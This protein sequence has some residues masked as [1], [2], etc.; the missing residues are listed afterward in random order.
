MVQH[1]KLGL[2][3]DLNEKIY[4]DLQKVTLQDIV[5]FE[6]QHIA[7]KPYRYVILGDEQE[8]DMAALNAIG[9]VRRISTEEIFGY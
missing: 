9:P 4:N 1:E 8:L 3:Y 2:N 5:N 6:Q 7:H